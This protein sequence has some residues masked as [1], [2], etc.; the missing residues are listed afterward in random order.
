MVDPNPL[1]LSPRPAPS[2][3][4]NT[5][6][7]PA[8][9]WLLPGPTTAKPA[10]LTVVCIPHAGAGPGAYRVFAQRLAPEIALR[11]VHLPGRESRLAE[12]PLRCVPD[13]VRALLPKLAPQLRGR[14]AVWGHSMGAYVGFE[15]ARVLDARFGLV[16]EA[17]VVAGCQPPRSPAR[18][19]VPRRSSM[20]DDELWTSAI[21]LNGIPDEISHSVELRALLLPTLRADFAVFETYDCQP[22]Q[23]LRCP[24]YAFGGRSDP[25]APCEDMLYWRQET[26]AEF[27]LTC[28]SGGHFFH[29]ED[30]H[31]FS[32]VL[33]SKL[34]AERSTP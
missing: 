30:P 7:A 23:L 33:S 1:T 24:L 26:R 13:I 20:P 34:R 25:E 12:P 10:A 4:A 8:P 19:S 3:A 2:T 21:A 29:F 6:P 14:F 31:G 17:L 27:G 28:M 9:D 15:L 5:P 32:T 18:S 11:V 22:G 16:P